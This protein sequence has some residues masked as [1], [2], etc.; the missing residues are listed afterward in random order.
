MIVQLITRVRG[1]AAPTPTSEKVQVCLFQVQDFPA[2]ATSRGQQL[3]RRL[4][5][6][7]QIVGSSSQASPKP[8][9]A[10]ASHQR[11]KHCGKG[12][13]PPQTPSPDPRSHAPRPAPA[14]QGARAP[15]SGSRRGR[16]SDLP[17]CP[18]QRVP[19]PPDPRERR[20]PAYLQQERASAPPTAA[21]S[22]SWTRRR[23]RG[24]NHFGGR[25][26]PDA[27]TGAGRENLWRSRRARS[28]AG[29]WVQACLGFARSSRPLGVSLFTPSVRPPE[30]WCLK[31][32][33][34]LLAARSSLGRLSASR[35]A[36]WN[37]APGGAEAPPRPP[38]P[39]PPSRS[40]MPAGLQAPTA[41]PPTPRARRGK[42]AG[43]RGGA[44]IFWD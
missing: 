23:R 15:P 9:Q 40:G 41:Q 31:Q 11:R 10:L 38:R 37:K 36:A 13:R 2:L 21:A 18:Q 29:L 33:S 1:W 8:L 25:R 42:G 14:S 5:R 43:E 24:S 26:P 19:I 12:A 35:R 30:P 7:V 17:S 27:G 16:C 28:A 22:W 3:V 44:H 4:S 39:L 32:Q 20:Q 6:G 34:Q